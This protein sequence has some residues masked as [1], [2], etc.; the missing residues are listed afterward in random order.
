[1]SEPKKST[2]VNFPIPAST[3]KAY[4]MMY[5][6][7]KQGVDNALSAYVELWYATISAISTKGISKDLLMVLIAA[8][9][10]REYDAQTMIEPN[11]LINVLRNHSRFNELEIEKYTEELSNFDTIEK[12]M[13]ADWCYQYNKMPGQHERLESLLL[14]V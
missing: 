8:M 3:A 1:M 10:N 11:Y 2:K 7:L 6:S 9:D 5:P 13:I 4:T 14:K 12:F